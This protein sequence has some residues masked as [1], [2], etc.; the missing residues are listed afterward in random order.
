VP[1][2]TVSCAG[3]S[4]AEG[5]AAV[6]DVAEE[7]THRPWQQSVHCEWREGLLRLTATNDFDDDGGALLDEF[8][9]AVMACVNSRN[10]IRFQ[11]GAVS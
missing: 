11:I 2:I 1:T 10:T 4:E 9:D 5:Y 7:F 3:L 6:T 8:R